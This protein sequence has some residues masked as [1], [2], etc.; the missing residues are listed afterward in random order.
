MD[1]V[2]D[3]PSSVKNKTYFLCYICLEMYLQDSALLFFMLI[4]LRV[5]SRHSG[6]G[7]IIWPCF[8]ATGLEDLTV[9]LSRP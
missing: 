1:A 3:N 5:Q 4:S 2:A 7:V 9:T 8:S 6:G